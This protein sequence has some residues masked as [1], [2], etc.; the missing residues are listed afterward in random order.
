MQSIQSEAETTQQSE[1]ITTENGEP[2]I[3][4]IEIEL[5]KPLIACKIETDFTNL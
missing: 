1:P 3:V 5:Y 2:T 4:V